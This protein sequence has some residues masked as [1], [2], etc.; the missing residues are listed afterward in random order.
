[1]GVGQKEDLNK[2]AACYL[3]LNAEVRVIF[4]TGLLVC[5][6]FTVSKCHLTGFPPSTS[7]SPSHYHSTID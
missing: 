6:I 4:L 2:Y 1:M 5:G 7:T 3:P